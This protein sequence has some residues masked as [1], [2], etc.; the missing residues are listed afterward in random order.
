MDKPPYFWL[1]KIAPQ[2]IDFDQIPL[3]GNTPLF[4]YDHFSSLLTTK[5]GIGPIHVTEKNRSWATAEEIREE[6]VDGFI[7]LPLKMGFLKGS[8]FW[9]MS[10]EN[11]AQLCNWMLTG[12]NQKKSY[13]SDVFTEGFYRFLMLQVIQTISQIQPFQ[14]QTI[15]LSEQSPLPETDAFCIDFDIEFQN[16]YC[17]SRLLIE[18]DLQKS[19]AKH[20]ATTAQTLPIS[21]LSKTLELY[22]DIQIGSVQLESKEL[23]KIKMGD[24]VLLDSHTYHPQKEKSFVTLKIQNTPLFQA[25]LKENQIEIIKSISVH[26]VSM[27]EQAQNVETISSIKEMPIEISVELARLS[28]PLDKLLKLSPGN[29]LDLPIHPEQSVQLMSGSKLIGRAELVHLGDTLGIRIIELG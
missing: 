27:K 7:V 11:V 13:V 29:F 26:E 1:Q 19:W 15:I 18:P 20:F 9:V 3:F 14:K 28:I 2:I 6:T 17:S 25:K 4:D 12:K 22:L 10:K 24:V 21:K 8:A 23:K 16:Q 5:F